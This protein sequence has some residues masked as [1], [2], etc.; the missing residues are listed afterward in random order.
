M[1]DVKMTAAAASRVKEQFDD[2]AAEFE[3]SKIAIQGMS[4]QIETGCDEFAGSIESGRAAFDM[5]WQD[6]FQ[7]CHTSSALIAGNT[8][9]MKVDLDAL[10][11][12]ASTTI[13]L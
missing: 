6:A 11:T 8:N 10:D 12:D 1:T 9:A 3:N 5:S 13:Q 2:L 7:F 4:E